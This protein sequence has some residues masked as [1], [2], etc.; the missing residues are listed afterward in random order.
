MSHS[1]TLCPSVHL[2]P[3]SKVTT[4]TVSAKEV[5]PTQM[6]LAQCGALTLAG[7]VV[8]ASPP[9]FRSPEVRCRRCVSSD[10]QARASG[11]S[12][13]RPPASHQVHASGGRVLLVRPGPRSASYFTIRSIS[14]RIS[15]PN[16]S[17]RIQ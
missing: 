7:S 17:T 12:P 8:L 15:V 5:V 11:P 13:N 1:F 3:E 16:G 6:S 9:P 10:W 4:L 14:R 2:H